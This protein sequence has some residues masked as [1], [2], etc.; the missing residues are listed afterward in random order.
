[1]LLSAYEYTMVCKQSE[2]KLNADALWNLTIDGNGEEMND[3]ATGFNLA[4]LDLYPVDTKTLQ[5]AGV[6]DRRHRKALK[7]TQAGLPEKLSET[8]SRPGSIFQN[9]DGTDGGGRMPI[10]G[11]KSRYSG[12]MPRMSTQRASCRTGRHGARKVSAK[13]ACLV[14]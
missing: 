11:P 7:F 10:G 1:M 14:A 9:A 8:K 2:D 13:T 4:K 6:K 3:Y 5:E 12:S